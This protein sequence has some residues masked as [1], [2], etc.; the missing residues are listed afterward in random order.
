[1]TAEYTALVEAS[2]EGR[3]TLLDQYGATNEGEFFAVATEC[4]FDKPVAMA[5]R[6]PKLYELLREYYRQDPAK[7]CGHCGRE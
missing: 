4:F 6:H 7:R 2:V 3:A 5:E 1:M